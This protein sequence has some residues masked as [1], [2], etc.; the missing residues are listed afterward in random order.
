M[1]NDNESVIVE[2]HLPCP[3][4][5]SHDALSLYSDGHTYCFSC[6]VYHNEDGGRE[7]KHQEP[8]V[9]RGVINPKDLRLEP[10]P[11]RHITT[12]TCRRFGYYKGCLHDR[13]AQFAC[14]YDDSGQIIGQKIRY[15]DKTFEILGSLQNRFFGQHLYPGGAKLKLVITEGEIDA[16]SV[17]QIQGNKYPVVSLPNGS[18]SA[19][20]TFE[21]QYEW[22][23]SFDE[24]ILMFDMD[25]PGQEAVKS[26]CGLLSPGKLK[27]ATLPLKDANDCLV[28]G[29]A[30]AVLDA[31]FNA[32]TYKPACILNGNELWQALS[33]ETED[34]QGYALPW[35]ID[36]QRMTL[37]LHKGELIII[38]AGTGTGK[39]T[40]VRQL[41]YHLG[42]SLQLKVGMMMLEE[43]VK[44]TAKGLM[45]VHTGKRLALNRHLVSDEEYKAAYD[46]TLGSGRYI[47]YEHFG[48]LESEDLIRSIRYMAAAEHCDFIILDHIS[49]AISGLDIENERKATD[50]LMTRLRSLVEETGVGMLVI[51]HLKRV[52]GQP[53]EEGGAISLSH[54]RGS[55][56]LSQLSDGVWALERNQQEEDEKKKNLVR[57]RVL[58]GRRTGET[59][60][61]GYL[62]YNKE[63][64]RLEAVDSIKEYTEEPPIRLDDS[65][66]KVPF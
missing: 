46:A 9:A 37:G 60:I 51:S 35:D 42:T 8:K 62:A 38:T 33:E 61:A 54:L 13:N 23:E 15:S 1:N 29:Q 32:K 63:T 50:V 12:E 65:D 39:T 59:G 55:Q 40:F 11:V 47:F 19:K 31:I 66:E 4:C 3:D 17:S 64:D 14:Y 25:K 49:I 41:A 56:A 30:K 2:A 22:L 16:L 5:G 52:D 7:D 10:L 43:N 34:E 57:I 20:K 44:R 27:I 26:V 24:V 45:S 58:K 36:L 48:S 18:K 6:D 53:A 21:A 28:N